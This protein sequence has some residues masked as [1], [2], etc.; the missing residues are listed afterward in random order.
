VADWDCCALTTT[1]SS[2]GTGKGKQKPNILSIN[3]NESL[4]SYQIGK[5]DLRSTTET[6]LFTAQKMRE[7][8][9]TVKKQEQ[10]TDIFT[11]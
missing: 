2:N 4:R 9:K 6:E 1:S 5:E 3:R 11:P 10:K 7:Q 8:R